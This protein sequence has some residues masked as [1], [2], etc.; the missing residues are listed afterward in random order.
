MVLARGGAVI[1]LEAP[2]HPSASPRGQWAATCDVDRPSACR[3]GHTTTTLV[4]CC[5]SAGRSPRPTRGVIGTANHERFELVKGRTKAAKKQTALADAV[6]RGVVGTANHERF[7]R[8][9]G[10]TSAAKKHTATADAVARGVLG[11]V[12]S[13]DQFE[14]INVPSSSPG[15]RAALAALGAA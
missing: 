11:M 3:R 1:P 7:E 8:V 9:Q 5:D 13:D 4:P 15:D 14:V 2:R 10:R 12:N 6:S